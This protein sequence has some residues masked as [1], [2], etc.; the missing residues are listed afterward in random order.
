[1]DITKFEQEYT[2]R[3]Y[4]CDRNNR[5]RVITL[6]NIFQ[7]M[8]YAHVTKLGFGLRFCLKNKVTWICSDYAI[9]IDRLPK[10]D[11]NIKIQ[12]WPSAEKKVSVTRDME[13]FGEDGTSIIRASSQWVLIDFVK[14]RPVSLKER[15]PEYDL[16]ENRALNTD[17]P[18]IA[19]LERVDYLAKFRVRYDDIDLNRHVNNAVYALW[20]CEAVDSDFRVKHTPRYIG[21][22]FRKEGYLGEK[23]MVNTQFDGL[24]T[25]HSINSYDGDNNREL[26]KATVVW[27]TR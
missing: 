18:K 19:D 8:S 26:S 3:S 9:E 2:V 21:I 25:T 20:A 10:M 27:Q 24:T 15:L 5:L 1:M 6:M 23:I 17:F 13:V 22:N 4:E 11:E 12:T 14:H 7:D 16:I